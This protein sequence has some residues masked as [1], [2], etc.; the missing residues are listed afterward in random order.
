MAFQESRPRTTTL[1]TDADVEAYDRDGVVVLRNVIS[2][3]WII[4]MQAA[5]DRV[6]AA[7]TAIGGTYGA[8]SHDMF[9]WRHDEDFRSFAMDSVL[10]GIAKALMRTDRLN[11]FFDQLLVKEP[12]LAAEI[13]WHQDLQTFPVS[14]TQAIS[15]WVP[16]DAASTANGAVSYARGSH[17]WGTMFRDRNYRQG[18]GPEVPPLAD[19][20][21]VSWELR[22]GDVVVHHPLTLH[23]SPGN[24]TAANRRRAL[25]VRYVGDDVRFQP[26]EPNF[27]ST[28]GIALPDLDEGAVLD[29]EMFPALTT[30]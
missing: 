29:H 6:I 2:A 13:K 18:S 12:G 16:F 25:S 23:G 20:D 15:I 10:P 27:M 11:L 9:L 24:A 26:K 21:V 19:M 14:G 1:V 22:P 7:P 17:L 30:A 28:N 8:F 3:D 5:V 4:R